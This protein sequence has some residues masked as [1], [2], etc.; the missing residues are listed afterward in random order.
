MMLMPQLI[1]WTEITG[2]SLIIVP[3]KYWKTSTFLFLMN[4]W[5]RK[6]MYIPAELLKK[7]PYTLVLGIKL[8]KNLPWNTLPHDWLLTEEKF[9][10]SMH[11]WKP[12]FAIKKQSKQENCLVSNYF[13]WDSLKQFLSLW[14]YHKI[15][16]Q[17]D[18]RINIQDYC[19]VHWF[20]RIKCNRWKINSLPYYTGGRPSAGWRRYLVYGQQPFHEIIIP[21]SY[22][23]SYCLSQWHHCTHQGQSSTDQ[24]WHCSCFP[25]PDTRTEISSLIT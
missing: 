5:S 14:I 3:E 21:V 11:N 6:M 20:P 13:S 22:A 8:L 9:L 19:E 18:R 2:N 16:L 24:R 15:N 12:G 10:N 1:T 4:I 17:A 7:L 25:G 23:L